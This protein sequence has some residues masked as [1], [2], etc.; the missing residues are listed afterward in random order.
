MRW[1]V[2]FTFLASFFIAAC[3]PVAERTP[4]PTPEV[5]TVAYSAAL[6]PFIQILPA[7]L[8]DPLDYQLLLEEVPSTGDPPRTA[9]ITFLLTDRPPQGW[10]AAP[11]TLETIRVVINAQ[12]PLRSLEPE[13][14]QRLFAGKVENWSELGGPDQ[15]VTVWVFPQQDEIQ[16]L[17]ENRFDL[18]GQIT[19]LAGLAATPP[20]MQKAIAADAGAIGL[21]PGAWLTKGLEAVES[22]GERGDLKI[23][24]L[25]LAEA[26]PYGAVRE[27]IACLQ[28]PTGQAALGARY[29][30]WNDNP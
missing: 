12:N 13:E 30:P 17:F 10:Y 15:A 5:V 11:V 28:G 2:T 18:Q 8:P 24:I 9:S 1:P 7:C 14:V 3:N 22:P 19:S 20:G 23:P 26:E 16:T 29:L 4:A 6:R 27:L 25:A 21:L